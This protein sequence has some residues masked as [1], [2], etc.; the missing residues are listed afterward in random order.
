MKKGKEDAEI[1][2]NGKI[3]GKLRSLN[4][5]YNPCLLLLTGHLKQEKIIDQN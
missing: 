2:H 3:K 1:N 4:L 5:S